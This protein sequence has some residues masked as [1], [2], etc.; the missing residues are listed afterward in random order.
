M[1]IA[2]ENDADKVAKLELCRRQPLAHHFPETAVQWWDYLMKHRPSPAWSPLPENRCRFAPAVC[3]PSRK[4]RAGVEFA[5]MKS[6][7]CE[8]ERYSPKADMVQVARES[9]ASPWVGSE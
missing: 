5:T 4:G 2:K 8:S 9:E 3:R 6:V 7:F 1:S